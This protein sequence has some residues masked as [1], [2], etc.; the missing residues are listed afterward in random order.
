MYM[1]N[2]TPAAVHVMSTFH[3]YR[4]SPSVFTHSRLQNINQSAIATALSP[5]S[6]KPDYVSMT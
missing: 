4:S 3:T 6:Q 1:Y 5:H 2:Y